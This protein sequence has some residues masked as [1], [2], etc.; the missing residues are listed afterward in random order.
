[1]FISIRTHYYSN[2]QYDVI[3]KDSAFFHIYS[4]HTYNRLYSQYVL[5]CYRDRGLNVPR[6]LAQYFYRNYASVT[7]IE[8]GILND[9]KHLSNLSLEKYHPCLVREFN[10]LH[11]VG[12]HDP[13]TA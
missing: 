12:L 11:R 4:E 7:Y 9:Y 10:R 2:L 13:S 3:I 6:H 1:M 8:T 5:R